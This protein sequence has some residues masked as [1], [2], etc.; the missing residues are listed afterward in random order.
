MC[1]YRRAT[2]KVTSSKVVKQ[3]NNVFYPL[4]L[5]FLT[6]LHQTD[7][8]LQRV[9][10]LIFSHVIYSKTTNKIDFII[11]KNITTQL[12]A[13]LFFIY[14]WSFKILLTRTTTFNGSNDLTIMD[15]VTILRS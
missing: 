13:H 14:V 12:I 8:F 1:Y 6:Y 3:K 10:S 2:V 5:I 15:H 9:Q 4:H 7:F 11:K